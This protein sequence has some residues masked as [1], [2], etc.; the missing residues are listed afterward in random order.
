MTV[1]LGILI[2]LLM[3]LLVLIIG[4][5]AGVV[6][7]A[8][9]RIFGQ[10][11]KGEDGKRPGWVTPYYLVSIL[12]LTAF[13]AALAFRYSAVPFRMS[14]ILSQPQAYFSG[15]LEWLKL[16]VW[17]G[18]VGILALCGQVVLAANLVLC[19]VKLIVMLLK[20]QQV[21]LS[22]W[23]SLF[24][25]LLMALLTL[26]YGAFIQLSF[27]LLP[28]L[29]CCV[30]IRLVW[31]RAK[32]LP[33]P[34]FL[35]V[36][37]VLL[38]LLGAGFVKNADLYEQ[39]NVVVRKEKYITD[40]T[41][42]YNKD[43]TIRHDE[44]GNKK[45]KT[46]WGQRTVREVRGKKANLLPLF[47]ALG[48][49]ACLIYDLQGTGK[50]AAEAQKQAAAAKTGTRTTAKTGTK[51]GTKTTAKTGTKTTAK[52]AAKTTAKAPAKSKLPS[53]G[54]Q[55]KARRTAMKQ[56]QAEKKDENDPT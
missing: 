51:T 16:W 49:Y 15:L 36:S 25:S 48:C 41:Y 37:L 46:S 32:K 33:M 19:A 44:D 50:I 9:L 12:L 28:V 2:A 52:T 38:V 6:S 39:D 24:I 43:G 10:P 45:L 42:K 14:G 5:L 4:V 11:K 35:W 34:S 23:G 27:V 20:K 54:E 53:A 8:W 56:D 29:L 3:L 7:T 21:P 55:E 31:R 30:I 47:F 13:M 22:I 18:P 40:I 26:G 17:P 1:I